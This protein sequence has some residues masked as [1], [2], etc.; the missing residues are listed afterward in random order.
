M[1]TFIIYSIKET[2][3]I[4]LEVISYIALVIY[5]KTVK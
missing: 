1:H 3:E 5:M 2:A 4:V